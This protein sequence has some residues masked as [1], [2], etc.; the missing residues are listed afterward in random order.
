MSKRKLAE[1]KDSSYALAWRGYRPGITPVLLL[2]YT[3]AFNQ[4]GSQ[5]RTG[6]FMIPN[7]CIPTETAELLRLF[8]GAGQPNYSERIRGH[9]A[10]TRRA[11]KKAF[12]QMLGE[13]RP[14]SLP[15]N[16]VASVR[17]VDNSD[18]EADVSIDEVVEIDEPCESVTDTR[19]SE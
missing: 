11:I 9:G 6:L 12:H 7:D 1:E 4:N 13:S 5:V 3:V 2:H 14:L 15:A 10:G 19:E 18:T 16:V 17:I 8:R